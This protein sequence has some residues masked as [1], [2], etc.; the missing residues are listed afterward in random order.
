MEKTAYKYDLNIFVKNG[1]GLL[2]LSRNGY[3]FWQK[4][5]KI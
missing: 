2:S 3:N 1:V 5:F 4:C